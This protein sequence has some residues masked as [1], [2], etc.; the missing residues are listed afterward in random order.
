M[1]LNNLYG[2]SAQMKVGKDLIGEMLL[3]ITETVGRGEEVSFEGFENYLP[4]NATYEIKKCADKLKDCVCLILGC[5]RAQLE[6]QDFKNKELGPDWVLYRLNTVWFP[7]TLDSERMDEN[8]E[9]VIYGA[10]EEAFCDGERERTYFTVDKPTFGNSSELTYSIEKEF[11]T[12]RKI[13]QILGTQGGRMLIHPNIW[14][15][16]LFSDYNPE[17][18]WDDSKWNNPIS[19]WIIT[20][21]RFPANEGQAVLK[22]GGLMIGVRRHF[23]LRFP[24]Y[25]HLVNEEQ[26]YRIPVQLRVENHELYNNL[27]HESESEMGDHSWC[28]VVIENNGTIEELFN[29]VLNA[30]QCQKELL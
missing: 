15:N 21:V 16:A 20:D 7:E 9:S 17:H 4:F 3:Y 23:A 25:V 13:L 27:T 2:V 22:R 24:E 18:T 12:P 26:P 14:V 30:V 1:K 5:T 11:L 19:K 8:R 6:D 10:Y 28:D 29:N